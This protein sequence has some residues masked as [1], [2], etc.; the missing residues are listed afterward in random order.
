MRS[1]TTLKDDEVGDIGKDLGHAPQPDA[2]AANTIQDH[3]DQL[4]T[5]I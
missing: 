5:E 4:K 3:I 2:A 1:Y